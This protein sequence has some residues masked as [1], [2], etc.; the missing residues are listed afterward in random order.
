MTRVVVP[1][2]GLFA[3]TGALALVALAPVVLFSSSNEAG[4]LPSAPAASSEVARVT[5]PR[6]HPQGPAGVATANETPE[7]P[8]GPSVGGQL[9]A[10]SPADG[11]EGDTAGKAAPRPA[12]RGGGPAI[13]EPDQPGDA[14]KT[15]SKSKHKRG[16][17]KGHA[18][19]KHHG[20][21]KGHAKWQ[22]RTV[23]AFAPRGAK[24]GHVS[25]P[26]AGA[27]SGRS[28]RPYSR[29]RR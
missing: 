3:V 8:G 28:A 5:A 24:P 9:A 23:V 20:K 25:P 19:P 6:F 10:T 1:A 27:R 4:P 15:T 14:G 12:A 17:A 18:K 29:S 22:G 21:A 16:K 26:R 13:G 7:A 11:V 2:I